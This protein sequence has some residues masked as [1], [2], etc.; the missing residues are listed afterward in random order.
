M[1][2][3][4]LNIL[5][6]LFFLCSNFVFCFPRVANGFVH[7]IDSTSQWDTCAPHAILRSLHAGV[8]DF[9]L[10]QDYVTKARD[11][12]DTSLA[13]ILDDAILDSLQLRYSNA[14]K[15][16]NA[17]GFIAY[18]NHETL[19]RILKDLFWFFSVRIMNKIHFINRKSWTKLSVFI[20]RLKDIGYFA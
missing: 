19:I 18:R 14:G 12:G 13:A 16:V 6:F 8:L 2:F 7:T 11:K 9:K 15:P 20:V 3:K 17:N 5:Y 4:P 1:Y 10:V